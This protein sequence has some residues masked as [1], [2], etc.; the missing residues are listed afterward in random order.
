MIRRDIKLYVAGPI[1]GDNLLDALA[2]I[3]SGEVWQARLFQLGFSPF[4]VFSDYSFI[5][6]VR[7]VPPIGDVYSYSVAWLRVA[8]AMLLLSGWETSVGCQR[9]IKEAERLAIPVFRDV[10]QLCLWAD[11]MCGLNTPSIEEQ[12]ARSDD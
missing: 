8:D 7:P 12:L 6:R 1:Q 2:N 5:M 9:E 4:P 3:N 10:D 11:K